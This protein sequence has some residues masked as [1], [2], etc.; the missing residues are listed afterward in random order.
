MPKLTRR[1][2]TAALAA[3]ALTLGLGAAW[4]IDYPAPK[5]LADGSQAE[6]ST[7]KKT[8]KIRIAYMPPATE[9]NIIWLSA[10]ASRPLPETPA[11]KPLC[12]L[13]SRAPTSTARWG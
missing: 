2:V 1:S 13:R 12:S 3:T 7:I 4:A 9:F 6:M 5:P 10:R 8:D 11:S